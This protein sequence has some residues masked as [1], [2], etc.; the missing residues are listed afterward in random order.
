MMENEEKNRE[1]EER[2][3]RKEEEEEIEKEEEEEKENYEKLRRCM[4]GIWWESCQEIQRKWRVETR[5]RNG[6]CG[7][8]EKQNKGRYGK[9]ST[10]FVEENNENQN[11]WG[12][13]IE[14]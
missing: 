7:E 12:R 8:Q 9:R 11:G 5:L 6:S 3:E 4:K 10:N 2:H 1:I 14:Y 13:R